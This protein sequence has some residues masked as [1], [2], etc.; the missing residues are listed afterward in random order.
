MPEYHI[1]EL[2]SI[3]AWAE[4]EGGWCWNDS[5]RLEEGIV[6]ADDALTPRKILKALRD[7]DYLADG[8]KGR[9]RVVEDWPV[10]E[11]QNKSNGCPY[12][13]LQLTKTV[14]EVPNA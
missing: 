2:C 13:A 10:I 9:L 5:F 6:F 12:L 8:S 14:K 3:D 7:W 4:P 1:F 11:I